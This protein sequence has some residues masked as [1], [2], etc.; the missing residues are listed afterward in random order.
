MRDIRVPDS[1]I[2]AIY[3]LFRLCSYK[4]CGQSLKTELFHE[5]DPASTRSK[6]ALFWK[7]RLSEAVD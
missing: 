2:K 5:V 3:R 1:V 7:V 6:S 4:M